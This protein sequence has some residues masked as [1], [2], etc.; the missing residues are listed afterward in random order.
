[1]SYPSLPK[2]V[3]APKRTSTSWY[4]I[5]WKQPTNYTDAKKGWKGLKVYFKTWKPNAKGGH[6]LDKD[7]KGASVSSTSCSREIKRENY[8]P[9]SGKPKLQKIT[10]SI[11][12]T[13]KNGKKHRTDEKE[14][15]FKVPKN[16]SCEFDYDDSTGLLTI[17]CKVK[18]DDIADCYD[19]KYEL[20]RQDTKTSS[21]YYKDGKKKVALNT[22]GK[23]IKGESTK[24]EFTLY[25][26]VEQMQLP[27]GSRIDFTLI[28]RARGF[29]GDA[30]KTFTFNISPPKPPSITKIDLSNKD[31][32]SLSN[33]V[34]SYNFASGIVR[35]FYSVKNATANYNEKAVTDYSLQR[36][37][38]RYAVNK[39]VE[40]A[41]QQGWTEV[42]TNM[43]STSDQ[44]AGN[45]TNKADAVMGESMIDVLT[46]MGFNENAHVY[47]ARVWYRVKSVRQGMV[48]YS[49]PKEVPE[50]ACKPPTAENDYSG[51]MS[52][53]NSDTEPGMSIDGVVGWAN[54]NRN[55]EGVDNP[56][57]K[58]AIWTTIVEWS[59]HKDAIH[60]NQQPSVLEMDW[61]NKPSVHNTVFANYQ[62][63]VGRNEFGPAD[64]FVPWQKSASFSIYGLTPGT[65]Y[66]LWTR[67][68]MVLGEYNEY[69]PRT[70]AP[71][72]FF[73]FVPTDN[74]TKVQVY[75][76]ENY[77]YGRDLLVSWAHDAK[78]DQTAWN[79][80]L[81]PYNESY[82]E[83][84]TAVTI[85]PKKLIAS[86]TGL[87]N[88][89]KVP[90]EELNKHQPICVYGDN[91]SFTIDRKLCVIVGVSTGGK[92]IYSCSDDKGR[93]TGANVL[94][95]GHIPSG[96]IAVL[97]NKTV[98]DTINVVGNSQAT[99]VFL[100]YY[101]KS[102]RDGKSVVYLNRVYGNKVSDV[103]TSEALCAI[104]IYNGDTGSKL[105]STLSY[106]VTGGN[107]KQTVSNINRSVSTTAN[108][109]RIVLSLTGGSYY[110]GENRV[111]YDISTTST[112]KTHNLKSYVDQMS[113][114]DSDRHIVYLFSRTKNVIGVVNVFAKYDTWYN[115]P[116]GE[117]LQPAGECVFT[118]TVYSGSFGSTSSMLNAD[119]K[120]M[121]ST[122]A[123][124]STAY[125][126]VAKVDTYA[127]RSM[128]D[129]AVYLVQGYLRDTGDESLTSSEKVVEFVHNPIREARVCGDAS[130]IQGQ[131]IAL[132]QS[133]KNSTVSQ[134]KG[135]LD[136]ESPPSPSVELN[137]SRPEGF[138]D[139]D[140]F[141][142]YRI[143][144][145]GGV[146]IQEDCVFGT[147]IVDRF[148][149]YSNDAI[150]RYGIV[151]ITAEGDMA[152]REVKYSLKHN[153]GIRFDWGSADDMRSL[154]LPLDTVIKD[155][156]SKDVRIDR[157]LDGSIAANFNQGVKREASNKA[158]IVRYDPNGV[159]QDPVKFEMIRELARHVGPV[160]FRS[161]NGTAYECVV[162]VDG[163]NESYDSLS[164][165]ISFKLTEINPPSGNFIP[166]N[167]TRPINTFIPPAINQ[168]P[169]GTVSKIAN[170]VTQVKSTIERKDVEDN[171]IMEYNGRD[172][173]GNSVRKTK[174]FSTV[175]VKEN[176]VNVTKTFN[177]VRYTYYTT[178]NGDSYEVKLPY[179]RLDL[180]KAIDKDLASGKI[181]TKSGSKT[182]TV[183]NNYG[184]YV[185]L[186][187]KKDNTTLSS[188]YYYYGSMNGAT[189]N[190]QLNN[191]TAIFNAKRG[192]T[193]S[194]LSIKSVLYL[195]KSDIESTGS[196][197][198]SEN[199]NHY[200]AMGKFEF[201]LGYKVISTPSPSNPGVVTIEFDKLTC[202][203]GSLHTIK[204]RVYIS[205]LPAGDRFSNNVMYYDTGVIEPTDSNKS[206][207][208]VKVNKKPKLERDSSSKWVYINLIV[209]VCYPNKS[210]VYTLSKWEKV[211]ILSL[212]GLSDIHTSELTQNIT[213]KKA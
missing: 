110:V 99:K 68:H 26:N 75:T 28:L 164:S 143:T 32:L 113:R 81:I 213:I 10:A 94:D 101:V 51:F 196:L 103:V 188:K 24:A 86:G 21:S 67:R 80:Y 104:D 121:L 128:F 161:D 154:E 189:Y 134:G 39:S 115:L 44:K 198:I 53:R 15:V 89:F 63:R 150:L 129:N 125:A 197:K 57:W 175:T 73:P 40:A 173:N 135:V 78:C 22:N 119:E 211:K 20:F 95:I 107:K 46:A 200:P 209:N 127:H 207:F 180:Q 112:T 183:K 17:T 91:K 137:I 172:K 178:I 14:L 76:E 123:T 206:K 152:W 166:T 55:D 139:T 177:E 202:T 8:Y 141:D 148:A 85:I 199:V 16:P 98:T 138:I 74:P 18:K 159:Y 87:M 41:V 71:N 133:L 184:V 27:Q 36:L 106:N 29:A 126:Y 169:K 170:K 157:Y 192:K 145:D 77:I 4:K 208:T 1:M 23:Q 142:L 30:S 194:T 2:S 182:V 201:D 96:T 158:K 193:D 61:E 187:A 65:K 149:P 6:T 56:N 102:T 100:D 118:T 47:D 124:G 49:E 13:G 35:V 60:S 174:D 33:N 88:S 120:E 70:K 179:I 3:T 131:K 72:K 153:S 69:G 62:D 185:K 147:K 116:D 42:D 90:A 11:L 59:D 54:A 210:V 168:V 140:R 205:S 50:L 176:G 186:T 45:K 167:I 48:V 83:G 97:T 111:K 43:G 37:V 93:Y 92:E 5:E 181:T 82:R 163:I 114:V 146:K 25:T 12:V 136:N 109:V 19:C 38:T 117:H 58:D 79:I 203:M 204:Y 190:Q 155:G 132:N 156:Y 52:I 162:E 7:G 122:Y 84:E 31:I 171:L 64:S 212:N 151:T 160:F 165:E 66:Y 195:V 108:S 191:L 130:I 105:L 144:P 34:L 9:L